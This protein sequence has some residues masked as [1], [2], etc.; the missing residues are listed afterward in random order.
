M[1]RPAVKAKTP[2]LAPGSD[3]LARPR[4]TTGF[5]LIELLL[6]L[7]LIA[8]ASGLVSLAL[9]DAD[10]NA[11]EREAARLAA[12]LESARSASRA[13]GLP[14]VFALAAAGSPGAA[15]FQFVGLPPGNELPAR[16]LRSDIQANLGTTAA[17][18]LGP[19]PLIG[20]QRITLRL[21]ERQLALVSDGLGPFVADSGAVP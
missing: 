5:T 21:G 19:E 18:A 6:V 2:T 20:A 14:V 15:D 17:L 7:L 10:A 8:L 12:L 1:V 3:T 13:S 4:H 11:L 9:R 16:W